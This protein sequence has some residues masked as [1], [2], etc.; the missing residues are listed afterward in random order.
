M[1]HERRL[2]KPVELKKCA[3]C[4][5]HGMVMDQKK[6]CHTMN[7]SSS[8]EECCTCHNVRNKPGLF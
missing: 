1:S 5:W 2:T 6:G 3:I 4:C 7:R 8:I